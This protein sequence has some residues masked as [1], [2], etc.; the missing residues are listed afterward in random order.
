MGQRQPVHVAPDRL[1][2]SPKM[3][4]PLRE[5]PVALYSVHK[6]GRVYPSVARSLKNCRTLSKAGIEAPSRILSQYRWPGRFTP[7]AHQ[8]TTADFLV[9]HERAFVFLDMGLGK[10]ATVLWA[11]DYL[12]RTGNAGRML[13]LCPLSCVRSVWENEIANLLPGRTV[14]LMVGSKQQRLAALRSDSDILVMNHEGLRVLGSDLC[15]EYGITHVVADECSAYK[16]SKTTLWK[17]FRKVT[18]GKS[19]WMM[20]GTPCAQSPE[21][22]WA[23]CR[24]VCPER[25]PS[26]FDLWRAKV[27]NPKPVPGKVGVTKW[28]TKPGSMDM[29]F[30]VMHPAIRYSKDECLD[31]PEVVFVDRQCELTADQKRMVEDLKKEWQTEGANGEVVTVQTAAARLGKILQT[32]QGSVIGEHRAVEVDASPRYA[33]LKELIDQA[34]GKAFVLA[35][36]RAVLHKLHR[37]LTADGYKVAVIDGDVT[38]KKRADIIADFQSPTGK[39]NVIVAHPR[40]ASHGLTLTAASVTVW[41]GATTSV[42]TYQQANNRMD[43]PGQRNDM[44]IAHLFS[45][46]LERQ[47]YDAVRNQVASQDWLLDL[48]KQATT[49]NARK[50]N[51]KATTE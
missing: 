40:T 18:E 16:N 14:G 39:T 48:Y 26:H 23:Y 28:V 36:Y 41:Y 9:R 42:E 5:L 15:K 3:L 2:Y 29:V 51:G 19:V 4:E 30:E 43:R 20:T 25:V 1:V 27:C 35:P 21:D 38:A 34:K 24:I 44:V 33:V 49:A 31:M 37:D 13:V 47:V 17:E 7:Y 46:Q 45:T 32:Y 12:R 6:D 10:S 22:A 11:W 8:C 50:K